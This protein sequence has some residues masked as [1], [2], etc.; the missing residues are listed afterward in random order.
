MSLKNNITVKYKSENQP[1]TDVDIKIDNFN[2]YTKEERA[3][4][5]VFYGD[6]S[7]SDNFDSEDLNYIKTY[8]NKYDFNIQISFLDVPYIL[9]FSTVIHNFRCCFMMFISAAFSCDRYC[10]HTFIILAL[11]CEVPCSAVMSFTSC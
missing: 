8:P 10:R 5:I 1:V 2:K 6:L 7:F 11:D 3:V 9:L 4:L